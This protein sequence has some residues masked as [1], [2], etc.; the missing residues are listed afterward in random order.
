MNPWKKKPAPMTSNISSVNQSI[1]QAIT[2]T[3]YYLHDPNFAESVHIGKTIAMDGQLS[4]YTDVFQAHGRWNDTTTLIGYLRDLEADSKVMSI[5]GTAHYIAWVAD[6]Y[7]DV[8]LPA[9]MADDILTGC[10]DHQT[11]TFS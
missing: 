1:M 5:D 11:A 2:G 4:W 7:G 8:F 3:N 9:Q 6:E 10:I